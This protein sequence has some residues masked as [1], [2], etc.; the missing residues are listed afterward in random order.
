MVLLPN[1][2]HGLVQ[3]GAPAPAI[4]GPARARLLPPLPPGIRHSPL[5]A[6]STKE[7]RIAPVIPMPIDP[8]LHWHRQMGISWEGHRSLCCH[9]LD[10][11]IRCFHDVT[12]YCPLESAAIR[13]ATTVRVVLLTRDPLMANDSPSI[14][15][16]QLAL[17][18]VS[19]IT[20][21]MQ[22]SS[23]DSD[24]RSVNAKIVHLLE[25]WPCI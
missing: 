3:G 18:F 22:Q 5:W 16:A 21:E 1:F 2:R 4:S 25:Q 17:L 7:M 12:M 20:S 9:Q 19:Y 10:K 13:L 23:A 14:R 11:K 15:L 8:I 24:W 6:H